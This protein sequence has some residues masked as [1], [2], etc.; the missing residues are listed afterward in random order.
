MAARTH[1]P[2][3]A[4]MSLACAVLLALPAVAAPMRCDFE[5]VSVCGP[6]GCRESQQRPTWL[7]I[8]VQGQRYGRCEGSDCQWLPMEVVPSGV[9]LDLNFADGPQGAKLSTLDKTIVEA[10]SIMDMVIVSRGS[11]K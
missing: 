4:V 10:V 1:A 5:R 9:Y 7:S 2:A 8:D 3:L 11:C 6:A